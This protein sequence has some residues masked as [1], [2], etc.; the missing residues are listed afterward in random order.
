MI[1]IVYRELG[2]VQLQRAYV[3]QQKKHEEVGIN[4]SATY[5]KS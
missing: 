1:L 5:S 2:L 4:V 3:C